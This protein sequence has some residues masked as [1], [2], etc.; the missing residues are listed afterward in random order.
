[1]AEVAA[2][3]TVIQL[4]QFSAQV[5]NCCYEYISK[6]KHAPKEIQKVIDEISSLKGVLENLKPLAEAPGDERFEI[7]R[8]LDR[9]SGPFDACTDALTEIDQKLRTLTESSN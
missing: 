9:P 5:L 1:M 4:V 6:A 2:A 3:A 7:L 8:S